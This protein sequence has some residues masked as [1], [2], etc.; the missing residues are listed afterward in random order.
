MRAGMLPTIF[1]HFSPGYFRV[2]MTFIEA[3][4]ACVRVCNDY[5]QAAFGLFRSDAFCNRHQFAANAPASRLRVRGENIDVPRAWNHVFQLLQWH[6]HAWHI[7]V[8]SWCRIVVQ[9]ITNQRGNN[10]PRLLSHNRVSVGETTGFT[11][12]PFHP[13]I[14]RRLALTSHL[15]PQVQRQ[16]LSRHIH[17]FGHRSSVVRNG[18][19]VACRKVARHRSPPDQITLCSVT[20]RRPVPLQRLVMFPSYAMR[21]I[22]ERD[23]GFTVSREIGDRIT[24]LVLPEPYRWGKTWL[25]PSNS[26]GR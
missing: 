6:E 10:R 7:R 5:A 18:V 11:T 19:P 16:S 23:S 24:I 15:C 1:H 17:E 13:D 22:K 2:S 26:P 9:G 4:G 25:S 8:V 12:C 20:G 14:P 3:P 21:K